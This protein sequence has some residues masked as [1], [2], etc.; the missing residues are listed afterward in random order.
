MRNRIYQVDAFTHHPFQGNPAGVCILQSEEDSA[1]MQ[2]VAREM[3]LSETAF[4]N[5]EGDGYH[6]RWFTPATEVKLCGHATLASAHILWET[7]T[8]KNGEVAYFYTL[9][10]LLTAKRL[11]D[12]IEMDFPARQVQPIEIPSGLSHALGEMPLSVWQRENTW[13]VELADETSVRTLAPDFSALTRLPARA[14]IVTALASTSGFDFVSR[15]FA[16]AIG[17]NEDPVTGSAHCYLA[18]FWSKRLGKKVMVGSQV[19]ARGGVVGVTDA[20]DRTLLRGQAVT[21]LV[22]DLLY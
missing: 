11:D 22:A 12:W 15:F 4:L 19:S 18:P 9:S 17:I 3:A 5:P 6:L 13:L 10:G 20:G 7:G 1:W 2:A 21:T 8:L 14:I 16:P